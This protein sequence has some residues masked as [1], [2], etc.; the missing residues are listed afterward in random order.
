MTEL[1]KHL[2]LDLDLTY[3]YVTVKDNSS[4]VGSSFTAHGVVGIGPFDLTLTY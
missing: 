1:L 4:A 3:N 2:R